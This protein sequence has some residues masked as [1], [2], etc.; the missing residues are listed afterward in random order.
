MASIVH[1]LDPVEVF[2]YKRAAMDKLFT[3]FDA[4]LQR[5]AASARDA[6]VGH[7]A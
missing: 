1:A 6:A 7:A 2:P 3:A 5:R 4:A